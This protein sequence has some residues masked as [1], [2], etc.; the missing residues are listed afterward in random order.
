MPKLTKEE[1]QKVRER[2]AENLSKVPLDHIPS[3]QIKSQLL[4]GK[5]LR[6]A[7]AKDIQQ[8]RKASGKLQEESQARYRK[9]IEEM[10]LM[11]YMKTGDPENEQDMDQTFSKYMG[12]LN[13]LLEKV[14]DE[15]VDMALLL[16]FGPLVEGLLKD[17]AG[18]CLA[19]EGER[20]KAERGES[21]KMWSLVAAGVVAAAPC[22][23]TAGAVCLGLVA[24][25]GAIG[26]G[27]AK[28]VAKESLRGF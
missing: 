5:P 17:N 27:E 18:Y 20:L 19:A 11:G 13:D 23:M 4:N 14:E 16:S 25:V 7:N 1:Q 10:P 12:H 2:L 9:H 28:K 22:F 24:L 21:L 26:Y 15:S 3:D 8:I 6:R